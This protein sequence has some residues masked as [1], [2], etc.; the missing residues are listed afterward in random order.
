MLRWENVILNMAFAI[1]NWW[2][3]DEKE[4]VQEQ[5]YE[6]VKEQEYM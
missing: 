6:Q 4:P 3:L 5:M 1:L 2:Y